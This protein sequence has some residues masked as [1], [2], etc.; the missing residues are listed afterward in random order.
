MPNESQGFNVFQKTAVGNPHFFLGFGQ[1]ARPAR[2]AHRVLSA[3]AAAPPRFGWFR[4]ACQR[5]PALP[6]PRAPEV[7]TRARGEPR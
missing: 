1:N 2:R 5:A 3:R 6:A 4:V 7:L